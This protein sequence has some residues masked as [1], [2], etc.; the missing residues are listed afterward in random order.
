MIY[1]KL[2]Y[3]FIDKLLIIIIFFEPLRYPIKLI[4]QKI[5]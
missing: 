5:W 1:F 3:A 2:S 4:Y